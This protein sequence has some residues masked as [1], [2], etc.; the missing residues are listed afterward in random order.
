MSDNELRT[1]TVRIAAHGSKRG[2]VKVTTEMPPERLE[3][4]DHARGQV[5]R[6]QFVFEI[7]DR[8]LPKAA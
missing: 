3:E 1:T 5:T 4:L 2:W 6:S 7:I 8:A